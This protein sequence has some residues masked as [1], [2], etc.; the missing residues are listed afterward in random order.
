MYITN[1]LVGSLRCEMQH[2]AELETMWHVATIQRS[3]A[4]RVAVRN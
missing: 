2:L 4:A 3:N 1:A